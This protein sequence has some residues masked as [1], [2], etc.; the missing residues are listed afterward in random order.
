[1]KRNTSLTYSPNASYFLTTTVTKFTNIFLERELA[2][3]VIDNL[4]FY[5]EKF[6]IQIHAFVIMPNHIHLLCTMSGKGNVSQFMGQMKEFSAKQIIDWCK[7]NE[8]EDFTKIFQDSAREHLS[9]HKHQV[10]QNRFDDFCIRNEIQMEQ[11]FHYIHQNPLQK[12]WQL[13]KK[14]EDYFFSSARFYKNGED[15]GIK[16]IPFNKK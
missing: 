3:I 2:Q 7:N 6:Q 12:H 9:H 10:W 14:E 15:V 13:A 16:I 11:K 8:R 1:M 5:T 4:K